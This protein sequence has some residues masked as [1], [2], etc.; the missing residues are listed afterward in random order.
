MIDRTEDLLCRLDALERQNRNLRRWG[1]V[2]LVLVLAAGGMGFA[3][4][5]DVPKVLKAH[6]VEVVDEKGTV[7]VALGSEGVQ[8][9]ATIMVANENGET[10]FALATGPSLGCVLTMYGRGDGSESPGV[11]LH[12]RPGKQMPTLAIVS[13]ESQAS[14]ELSFEA[15][16]VPQFRIE[17]SKG[18]EIFKA[19]AGK[20]P[21]VT[22]VSPDN[23]SK[24]EIGFDAPEK[25]QITLRDKGDKVTFKAVK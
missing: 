8:S 1:G 13:P 7:R 24:G 2:S 5:Q 22:L 20:S 14:A 4:I 21:R 12:A 10:R 17:D 16:D 11:V 9:G 6:R 18:K 23:A 25:P 15:P 3:A 19:V